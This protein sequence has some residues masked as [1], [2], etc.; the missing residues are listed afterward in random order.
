MKKIA[1]LASLIL[2]LILTAS[3]AL[4]QANPPLI[5]DETV[6]ANLSADGSLEDI[7]VVNRIETKTAGIYTDYGNYE[8]I[9]PLSSNQPPVIVGDEIRWQKTGAAIY[10]QGQLAEGELPFTFA[11]NYALNGKS[12]AAQ[13]AVGKAGTIA[14]TISVQAN[15]KAKASFRENYMAQV[16]VPLH[17]DQANNIVAPG[18]MAVITG[19]TVTL[20]Y[21]VLP[22]QRAGFTVQFDTNNFELEPITFACTPFAVDAFNIDTTEIADGMGQL[23]GG[24]DQL[25]GGG[26]ELKQGLGS[27]SAGLDASSAGAGKFAQGTADLEENLPAL[28]EG[29]EGLRL[30]ALAL[31]EGM[32]QLSLG[33]GELATAA[34]DLGAG[35]AGYTAATS[36]FL[37]NAQDLNQGLAQLG[38]EGEELLAGYLE[39]ASGVEEVFTQLPAQLIA[40]LG[41]N[42]QQQDLLGYIMANL[43]EEF[44][45]QLNSF[46]QGLEEYT[47]GVS[48]T[49]QGMGE[50]TLGLE[51]FAS[52]GED[53]NA[54]ALDFAQG[55][56]DFSL[57]LTQMKAGSGELASGISTL[58]A[59]SQ[60]IAPG[61]QELA[62]GARALAVA[63]QEMAEGAR[64]LP[65]DVQALIDGQ[66]QVKEAFAQ[67]SGLLEDFG[68]TP[69][70]GPLE[71]FVS[72]KVV[73]RSVQFVAS[74][75]ALRGETYE[76][77]E[78]PATIEKTG[79]FARLLKLF[80]I[81]D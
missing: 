28:L 11:L 32:G 36:Q 81:T 45:P 39:L 16:Q 58:A 21:T 53:L 7:Y 77:P 75:P 64:R 1:G 6:Y 29:V 68:Q 30:G 37:T 80:K 72:D 63:M 60:D 51:A 70:T 27:L 62:A 31:D 34:S 3:S 40:V 35:I 74:T 54:G 71:S 66:R 52:A 19:R 57:G 55:T 65:A 26:Q 23:T 44:T 18:A 46:G 50:L 24:L 17:L 9:L 73:P 12:I 49:S 10:Y 14:I 4:S 5:K 42:S 78:P 20:A 48:L 67:A 59:E 76:T 38:S 33:A 47:A 43:S 56:A 25:I 41:F 8:S 22:G 79:F 69:G 61:V 13:D 15:E 2:I